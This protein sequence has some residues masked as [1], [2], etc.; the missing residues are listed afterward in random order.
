MKRGTLTYIS[1]KVFE[2]T[3]FVENLTNKTISM[4]IGGIQDSSS[5]P[6]YIANNFYSFSKGRAV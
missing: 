1:Y 4:H 5:I 2:Y 6:T 3:I